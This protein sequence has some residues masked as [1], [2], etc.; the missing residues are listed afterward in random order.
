VEEPR[1]EEIA[2]WSTVGLNVRV[3]DPYSLRSVSSRK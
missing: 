3:C 2:R 1:F